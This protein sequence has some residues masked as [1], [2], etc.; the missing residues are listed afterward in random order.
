MLLAHSMILKGEIIFY[1]ARK[2]S[3]TCPKV[4]S[5]MLINIKQLS[6]KILKENA[7]RLDKIFIIQL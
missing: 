7:L 1:S 3:K 2:K 5:R 6:T 4:K